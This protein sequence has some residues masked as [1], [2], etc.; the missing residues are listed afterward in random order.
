MLLD[1]YSL[2]PNIKPKVFYNVYPVGC[3]HVE[4][5][6]ARRKTNQKALKGVSRDKKGKVNGEEF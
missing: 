6:R 3:L 5:D 4:A 2:Y 1:S